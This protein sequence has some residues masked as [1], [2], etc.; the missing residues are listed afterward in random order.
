MKLFLDLRYAKEELFKVPGRRWRD[1]DDQAVVVDL[2]VCNVV[3]SAHALDVVAARLLNI[4]TEIA[5]QILNL[6]DFQVNAQRPANVDAEASKQGLPEG[7]FLDSL[8]T[9]GRSED[10]VARM[11]RVHIGQFG[12][13]FN[14]MVHAHHL[15]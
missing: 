3:R 6:L 15:R 12:D 10:I 4:F 7:V 5:I 11:N 13:F 1:Q 9:Q 2:L 8:M 14:L